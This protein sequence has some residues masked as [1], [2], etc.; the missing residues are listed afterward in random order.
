MGRNGSGKT[1]LLRC[2]LGLVRFEQGIV[3]YDGQYV[4]RS[5]LWKLAREGLFFLPDRNLLSRRFSFR[6][7]LELAQQTFGPMEYGEVVRELRVEGVL[8]AR[9][10][11]MSGGERR[12]AELALALAREPRCLLADEPLT[13]VEPKDRATV[14]ALLR[15]KAASGMAILV[16]GHEVRELLNLSDEIIWMAGGTTHGLGDPDE[17]R[18]HDQFKR[19]YLGPRRGGE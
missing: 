16:T 9:P 19:E 8:D 4:P 13:E 18:K 7:Q 2:A 3:R 10:D 17:A 1:T 14:M 5:R 12:R 11:E 15:A 6:E